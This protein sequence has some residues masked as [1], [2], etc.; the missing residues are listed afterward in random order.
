VPVVKKEKIKKV[1][2]G[3]AKNGELYRFVMI[4]GDMYVKLVDDKFLL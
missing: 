2:R 1:G 3:V 4:F